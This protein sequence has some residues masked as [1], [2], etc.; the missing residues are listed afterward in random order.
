MVSELEWELCLP[1]S[2]YL[3]L[4]SR[5]GR[6]TGFSGFVDLLYPLLC[7]KWRKPN[8]SGLGTCWALFQLFMQTFLLADH[9][10]LDHP[11][12]HVADFALNIFA[13]HSPRAGGFI[14]PP[15]SS[16]T[17]SAFSSCCHSLGEDS[18]TAEASLP[19]HPYWH[20][21]GEWMCYCLWQ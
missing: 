8:T 19:S 16:A 14:P 7:G 12:M 20:H 10:L 5:G 4:L 17:S 9:K 11:Q 2:E 15:S 21:C 13:Q 18:S 6:G 3:Q 1:L